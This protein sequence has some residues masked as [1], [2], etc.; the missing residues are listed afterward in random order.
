MKLN[1]RQLIRTQAYARQAM[2]HPFGIGPLLAFSWPWDL[3]NLRRYLC[4]TSFA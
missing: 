2:V 1:M 4:I 3:S